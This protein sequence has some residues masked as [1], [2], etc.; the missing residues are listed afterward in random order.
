MAR[1]DSCNPVRLHEVLNFYSAV[2]LR[3]AAT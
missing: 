3:V 2:L 1:F